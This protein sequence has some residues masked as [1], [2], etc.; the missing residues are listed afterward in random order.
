MNTN[1]RRLSTSTA[2][3]TTNITNTNMTQMS[4]RRTRMA[5]YTDRSRTRM[6]TIQ[7]CTIDIPIR[8]DVQVHVV[9]GSI[10]RATSKRLGNFFEIFLPEMHQRRCVSK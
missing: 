10:W 3:T 6:H 5:I 2:T 9:H 1:M 7:T 4:S 8:T